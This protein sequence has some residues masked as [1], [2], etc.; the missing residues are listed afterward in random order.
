MS[1]DNWAQCPRCTATGLKAL[2]ERDEAVQ[3]SY[4]KVPVD[5]FDEARR[6][7]AAAVREFD[8]RHNTFREDY[9]IY[10][11]EGGVITVEYAGS[12]S[13]CGLELSFTDQRPIPGLEVQR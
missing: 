3:A 6:Q 12:C 8:L 10:G 5:E 4:G 1:A 2:D 9:E 11:A 13:E 7:H